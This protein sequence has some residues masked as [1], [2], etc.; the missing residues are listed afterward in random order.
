MIQCGDILQNRYQIL[1]EIGRGGFGII[2]EIE[3]IGEIR[4]NSIPKILKVLNLPS[5][6]KP[7]ERDKRIELFK[8]E[9]QVLS[10]LNCD[11]IPKVESDGFLSHLSGDIE[12]QFYSLVM[13]KIEGD[14]LEQW[15]KNRD[16]TPVPEKQALNWLKEL[17]K[18]LQVIHQQNFFHRD[19]K[20]SNIIRKPNGQL[21][22]IDFGTV[23]E[24]TDTYLNKKKND[25][26]VT[27][28]GTNWYSPTEQRCSKAVI[29]SDFYALGRTFV[30]LLTG[31][32]IQELQGNQYGNLIW[33]NDST[34]KCEKFATLINDLMAE[35]VEDRPQT[36]EDI[37]DQIEKIETRLNLRVYRK[38]LSVKQW[39]R[40]SLSIWHGIPALIVA[41]VAITSSIVMVRSQGILQPLE[42]IAYDR[43]MR[44]R[45]AEPPDSRITIV[46]IT[47]ED[48]Q[49]LGEEEP[50]SD[51]TVL[52]LLQTLKQYK[53]SIIGLDIFRDIP[54]NPGHHELKQF[55]NSN[56]NQGIIGS[57]WVIDNASL[58]GAK[59]PPGFSQQKDNLGFV[60]VTKDEKPKESLGIIRRHLII[61]DPYKNSPCKTHFSLS[62]Q[63]TKSYI[64]N[65]N[66]SYQYINPEKPDWLLQFYSLTNT[67]NKN[68]K[69][70]RFINFRNSGSYQKID[71]LGY[72]TLLNYR[73]FNPK[74][75]FVEIIS[76]TEILEQKVNPNSIKNKIILIGYQQENQDWHLTPLGEMS[77]VMV[78][79]HMVSQLVSAILDD[80]PL[81]W[82]WSPWQEYLW[83][84][85]WSFVG[86]LI[87]L[88]IKSLR[89]RIWVSGIAVTNLGVIC[90]DFISSGIFDS[91]SSRSFSI[92]NSSY[93]ECY[94][95]CCKI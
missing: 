17:C 14:N 16:Y 51:R 68:I 75:P 69:I 40:S 10:K 8:R 22:L 36:V 85:S 39:T 79:A 93:R 9:F 49:N 80:R 88:R 53:P 55:F 66:F 87:I 11:G 6:L 25:E 78:H 41:S 67:N 5:D 47:D 35:S 64:N 76:I 52:D 7:E 19:I 62:F 60:N 72:K 44:L 26:S 54:I 58:Q 74:Q 43:L 24:V 91:S 95:F 33:E 70:P 30:R 63:I 13:E 46:E 77:G 38:F 32:Q 27:N 86:G 73:A 81:L 84:S 48:I 20:P 94:F 61:Q 82:F 1:K 56:Q 37:L 29:Q 4:Q 65:T 92:F 34:L 12:T 90:L 31:L 89:N 50:I 3:E 15:L 28:L 2:F 71:K 18:I 45:P 57:C 23:R 42:M 59:P 21:V 83:I